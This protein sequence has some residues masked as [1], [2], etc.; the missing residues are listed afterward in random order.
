MRISTL[1]T[2]AVLLFI[3]GAAAQ[4]SLSPNHFS[5]T[6]TC[7]P[8]TRRADLFAAN[9]VRGLAPTFLCKISTETSGFP[10]DDVSKKKWSRLSG[11]IAEKP[12]I[13]D[14]ANFIAPDNL[15]FV[16][17]YVQVAYDRLSFTRHG[18]LYRAIYD[19]DFY[20]ED[21]NGNLLQTQSGRDEF[22]V[23]NY[24]ETTTANNYRVTLLSAC[25]RPETYRRRVVMTD[26]ETGK[27]YE[28]V[29]KFSVR[30]FSSPN[31]SLSD[32]Q[33]SRGIQMDSSASAF[34]KH[35][36]RI[37][38]NVG[39]LY[40]QFVGQLFVYYEIYN[41]S[42][43]NAALS[44]NAKPLVP[45]DSA[46]IQSAA[47]DSFQTLYC[48][49]D[50]RGN[51]M[52]QLSRASRKP[53][54]SCVQSVT[55]PMTDLKSGHYTLTVRVF[56]HAS[57]GHAEVT[58]R[59]SVQWDVFT[60]KDKKFEELLAQ[61]RYVAGKDELKKL[62]QLPEVDRQ[63]G[64]LG[65]WQRRDPTPG[66]TRNEAM[67]EYYRRIN[68]ANAYFRKEGGEGWESSQGQ[69]YIKYGH[70]DN[71]QRLTNSEFDRANDG[72]LSPAQSSDERQ[73][74]SLQPAT[75]PSRLFNPLYEVWDYVQLNRRFVFVDSRGVGMYQLV[76][77]LL[78]HN[79]GWR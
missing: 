37:E 5:T 65:F 47:A 74:F 4:I 46:M 6:P 44:G 59:F 66:T 49:R 41:F 63:R 42:T 58:G 29:D 33:F 13:V 19:V 51:E 40:G 7:P 14:Q 21:L 72:W 22:T 32:L 1:W 3:N 34:V 25:L 48:I 52:K 60:F 8:A 71:V 75:K 31:L 68:Y 11:E 35:N 15:T 76:E 57:G 77:P 69:I 28:A 2:G 20:I 67:E 27:S 54:N 70:P 36:R 61:M 16:E 64:L 43:P 24:D 39:H 56:D 12:F 78:L 18:K 38:P 55:L 30:G 45:F 79:A 10:A 26:K 50:E 9:A 53:G 17:F 62:A 23:S 73:E